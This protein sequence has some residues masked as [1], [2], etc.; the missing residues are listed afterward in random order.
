MPIKIYS[1]N[2][3]KEYRDNWDRIF[4]KPKKEKSNKIAHGKNCNCPYKTV[5]EVTEEV[6]SNKE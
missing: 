1:K 3:T 6:D 4:K 5:C 2:Y